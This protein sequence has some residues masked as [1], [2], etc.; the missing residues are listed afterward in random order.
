MSEAVNRLSGWIDYDRPCLSALAPLDRIDYFELRI[1]LVL[2]RPLERIVNNELVGQEKSSALLIFAVSLCCAI[3]ATG[4][5]LTGGKKGI[6]R[7]DRFKKFIRTY[8]NPA[9]YTTELNG[10]FYGDIL[11]TSFR[12]G[13]AHGFAVCHGGF[14]S[15]QG[16][17]FEIQNHPGYACLMIN[18]KLL[19]EDYSDGF[20]KY[21]KD[22]RSATTTDELFIDFD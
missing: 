22:L 4:K 3:E 10:V 20:E 14:E 1:R 19:Y 9:F 5:F 12:N 18:P 17:Y 16:K 13:L 15:N 21:L 7:G 6:T 2:L 11:W 8:M